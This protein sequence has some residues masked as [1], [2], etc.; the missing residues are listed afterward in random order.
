MLFLRTPQLI[1]KLGNYLHFKQREDSLL[2]L[3]GLY[4]ETDSEVNES[5]ALPGRAIVTLC[6]NPCLRL[7]R[8]FVSLNFPTKTLHEF[9]FR[10]YSQSIRVLYCGQELRKLRLDDQ[11]CQSRVTFCCVSCFSGLL[12]LLRQLKNQRPI[13]NCKSD[14]TK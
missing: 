7:S 14:E 11:E 4:S 6:F 8:Y 5:V 13:V 10:T 2:H 1:R 12:V 9:L 3:H